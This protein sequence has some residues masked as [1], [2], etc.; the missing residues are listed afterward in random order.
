MKSNL[1]V[2]AFLLSCFFSFSAVANTTEETPKIITHK[3][4]EAETPWFLAQ[5]YYGSGAQYT[6]LL[7]SNGWTRPEEMKEGME[8]R[9]EDPK[10]FNTQANFSNRYSNLWEKRAKALGLKVDNRLPASK[11]VI[12][13]QQI[14]N[15][16]NTPKLPFT[17]VKDSGRSA[18]EMAH[19]ELRRFPSSGVPHGE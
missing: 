16:D 17:E 14:R 4:V 8:I 3:V 2:T 18:A 11:V 7:K 13:T 6:K 10:H 15:K 5:V 9:I 12:P 1:M 19:E